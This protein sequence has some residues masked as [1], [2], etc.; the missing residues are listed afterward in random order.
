[1][2]CSRHPPRPPHHY[3][4]IHIALLAAMT[5]PPLIVATARRCTQVVE[6]DKSPNFT[7]GALLSVVLLFSFFLLLSYLEE[8]LGTGRLIPGVVGFM[9]L[10]LKP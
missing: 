10:D 9:W 3:M 6:A 4:Y 5:S 1:M 2:R 7:S 8:K